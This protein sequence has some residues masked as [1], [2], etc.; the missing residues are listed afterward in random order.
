MEGSRWGIATRKEGLKGQGR[1]SRTRGGSACA[2]PGRDRIRQLGRDKVDWSGGSFQRHGGPWLA[3][4]DDKGDLSDR[5]QGIGA[6]SGSLASL[7][8]SSSMLRGG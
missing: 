8:N 3:S 2:N 4:G 5:W 6:S 1:A 7:A